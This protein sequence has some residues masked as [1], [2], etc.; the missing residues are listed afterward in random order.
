MPR[1]HE[2]RWSRSPVVGHSGRRKSAL[3]DCNQAIES[4]TRHGAARLGQVQLKKEHIAGISCSIADGVLP[5]DAF[6]GLV[7][8]GAR[9][10]SGGTIAGTDRA[11]LTRLA[12]LQERCGVFSFRRAPRHPVSRDTPV[13]S[14][15]RGGSLPATAFC[16]PPLELSQES[17]R[18]GQQGQ[19]AVPG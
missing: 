6:E 16:G 12:H 19:Q 1:E 14:P 8:H 9:P 10:R 17:H 18:R 7:E 4:A 5:K 13:R 2:S 11:F 3:I 15:G